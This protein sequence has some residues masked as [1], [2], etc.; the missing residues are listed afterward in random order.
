MAHVEPTH[1]MELALRNTPTPT[2]ADTDALRHIESCPE[3]RDELRSLT[4]LVTAARTARLADLPTPPP[5]HVWQRINRDLSPAMPPPPQHAAHTPNHG[6][7][8]VLALLALV[9]AVGIARRCTHERTAR[10]L[11]HPVP[12]R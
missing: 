7:R 4:R 6:K 11:R 9:A 3:C 5:A 8:I 2:E 10:P 1:L 12:G